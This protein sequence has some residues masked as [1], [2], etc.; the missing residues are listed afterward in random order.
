MM[1]LAFD[2][3]PTSQFEVDINIKKE[4]NYFIFEIQ[5]D[6][7]D[8]IKL[9]NIL[10][11]NKKDNLMELIAEVFLVDKNYSEIVSITFPLKE[12]ID[13]KNFIIKYQDN[14]FYF[15]NNNKNK[16]IYNIS[17]DEFNKNII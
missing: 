16:P 6:F 14:F 1:Q 15:V 4:N 3:I 2:H 12:D 11:S 7:G 9:I 10:T 17:I 13:I 8:L 5:N